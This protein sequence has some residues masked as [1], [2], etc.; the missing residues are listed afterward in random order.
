MGWIQPAQ[1]SPVADCYE[2]CNEPLWSI[3]GGEFFD[4]LSGCQLLKKYS[5][6]LSL[7][8]IKVLTVLWCTFLPALRCYCIVFAKKYQ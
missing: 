3:R 2:H 6:P 7:L 4:Q 1:Y 8:V 5:F